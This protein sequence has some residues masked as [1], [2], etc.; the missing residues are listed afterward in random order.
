[1]AGMLRGFASGYASRPCSGGYPTALQAIITS[2]FG[3]RV[4]S[5]VSTWLNPH[6]N[7]CFRW[8]M[9]IAQGR[10]SPRATPRLQAPQAIH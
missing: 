3:L 1:M 9:G 10:R 8:L 4:L 6:P 7:R 5:V 2:R